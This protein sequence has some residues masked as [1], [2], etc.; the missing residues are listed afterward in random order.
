[1]IEVKALDVLN[2]IDAMKSL[3]TAPVKSNVAYRI[4]RLAREIDNEYKTF[5]EARINLIKK[6]GKKDENGELAVNEDGQ[7][8]V[9]SENIQEFNKEFEELSNTPLQI[10]A[11]KIPLQDLDCDL[12]AE[13]MMKLMSFIE[14]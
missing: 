10:N 6:Y 8:T 3:M 11:E 9:E 5:D 7:W 2:S 4:A 14:E 1:M 13:T 12:S